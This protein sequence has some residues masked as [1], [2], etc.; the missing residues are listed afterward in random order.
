[1]NSLGLVLDGSCCRDYSRPERDQAQQGAEINPT[2]HEELTFMPAKETARF[3][4]HAKF[5][6]E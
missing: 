3:G 4:M 1:M 2:I 5:F 6:Q